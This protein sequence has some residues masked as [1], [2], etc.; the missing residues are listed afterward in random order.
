MLMERMVME[1]STLSGSHG[2]YSVLDSITMR[3][4]GS[5]G[6][7][8]EGQIGIIHAQIYDAGRGMLKTVF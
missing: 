3:P 5:V 1:N 6:D 8:G 2:T 7:E 4:A